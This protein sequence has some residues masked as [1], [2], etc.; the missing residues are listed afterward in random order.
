MSL[1]LKS[2]KPDLVKCI[3]PEVQ[4]MSNINEN[5]SYT[6]TSRQLS[7]SEEKS[8]LLKCSDKPMTF[9]EDKGYCRGVRALYEIIK[10][11]L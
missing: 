3:Y 11:A 9:A 1:Y 10:S 6:N 7:Y 8:L 2:H 5:I 4:L